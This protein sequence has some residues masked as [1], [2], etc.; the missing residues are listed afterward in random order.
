[1]KRTQLFW[2]ATLIV[3][4]ALVGC[5]N[6]E[7]P[8]AVEAGAETNAGMPPGGMDP[9]NELALGTLKLEGSEHA[10]TAEQAVELLPLWQVIQSG[11][12]QSS[13]ET[14]AVLRQIEGKMSADQLAAIEAMTLTFED[15]RTWMERQGLEMPA[16][17][18]GQPQPGAEM[19]ARPEGGPGGNG[20]FGDMTEQER[21]QMREQFQNM[22]QE[23]RATRAAEMGFERPEGGDSGGRQGGWQG[24]PGGG[25]R[26]N[27]LIAPLIDLLTERAGQ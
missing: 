8:A 1:M 11:A 7:P 13:A 14:Q 20:A 26:G 5:K 24:N 16:P 21:T 12:L 9:T 19:P 10:I 25:A 3:V 27:I 22:S 4:I 2:V 23:E 15:I 6:K 18:E 17:T